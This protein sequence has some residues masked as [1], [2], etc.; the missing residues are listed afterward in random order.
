MKDEAAFRADSEDGGRVSWQQGKT[1]PQLK[2]TIKTMNIHKMLENGTDTLFIVSACDLREFALA[3][4][5]DATAKP[6]AE[7][8]FLTANEVCESLNV[9]ASTLWRWGKSGYLVPKKVGRTSMYRQSDITNLFKL[10]K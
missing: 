7:E 5:A 4:I 10:N 3:L 1:R 8:K 2:I 9:S 6:A